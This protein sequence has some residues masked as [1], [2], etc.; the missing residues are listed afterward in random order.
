MAGQERYNVF[1]LPKGSSS[2]VDNEITK[3]LPAPVRA[4]GL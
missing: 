4:C 3:L 1:F 2:V